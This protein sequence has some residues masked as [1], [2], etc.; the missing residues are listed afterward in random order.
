[1]REDYFKDF[2][3]WNNIKKK[4]DKSSRL[5]SF[6]EKEIWWYSAGVNVGSEQDGKGILFARPVYILKKINSK[7]FIGLPLTSKLRE[8]GSHVS[9]YFNYDFTTAKISQFKVMDKK[10]L[11]KFRGITSDYLH[12]KMKKATVAFILS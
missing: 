4:L 8:D 3:R 11:L 9:F 5:I 12:N 7:T 1:M 10:R 6:N 2:D